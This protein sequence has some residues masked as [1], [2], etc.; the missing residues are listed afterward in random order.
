M[1]IKTAQLPPSTSSDAAWSVVL[2]AF[3]VACTSNGPHTFAPAFV[4]VY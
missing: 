3:T 1:R 2:V 4:A